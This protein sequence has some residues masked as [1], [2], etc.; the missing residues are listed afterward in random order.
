MRSSRAVTAALSPR[1]SARG[2]STSSAPTCCGLGSSACCQH[3]Y[4]ATPRFTRS[5]R[6]SSEVT[7]AANGRV[8]T[9]M[10]QLLPNAAVSACRR[11]DAYSSSTGPAPAPAPIPCGSVARPD[12][13][14]STRCATSTTPASALEASTTSLSPLSS[15]VIVTGSAID[16]LAG[17]AGAADAYMSTFT[18]ACPCCRAMTDPRSKRKFTTKSAPAM[19]WYWPPMRS[20]TIAVSR[21]R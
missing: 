19:T 20:C 16:A 10:C 13:A 8:S 15:S 17:S 6:P 14:A 1:Q 2:A 21:P 5:L 9:T 12:C 11:L 7:V 4:V 3:M 18:P